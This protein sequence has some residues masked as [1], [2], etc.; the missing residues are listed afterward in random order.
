MTQVV[1]SFVLTYTIWHQN[2]V[3]LSCPVSSASAIWNNSRWQSLIPQIQGLWSML[4]STKFAS[5]KLLQ[6]S[7]FKLG[8]VCWS[9]L[10]AVMNNPTFQAHFAF[11]FA[12]PY[13]FTFTPLFNFLYLR[14]FA[15]PATQRVAPIFATRID[16]ALPA[17]CTQYV[18]L[19]VS[20]A[21][22]RR[23]IQINEI[24]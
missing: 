2:I 6:T 21:V 20:D 12:A 15:S 7:G 9:Q 22:V 8:N 4:I 19:Q 14:C 13:K 3:V 18:I 17:F 23:F 24:A 5:S 10:V 11:H 1:F 16:V